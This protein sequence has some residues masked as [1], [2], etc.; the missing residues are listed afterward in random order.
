MLSQEHAINL[1]DTAQCDPRHTAD[2]LKFTN[3]CDTAGFETRR[4][5]DM[6]RSADPCD[7]AGYVHSTDSFGAVDGPGIRFLI[8]LQGCRMRCQYCH[9]PDTWRI[10]G[11]AKTYAD[12]DS[13]RMA[14][15]AESKR[16]SG[17]DDHSDDHAEKRFPRKKMTVSELLSKAERYRSYWKD[18]GGITVSGGEPLLQIDFLT[19]LFTEAHS[20]QINTALDTSAQPFMR[21]QP[22][23]GKFE[24]LMDST[25]LVLLDIKHID[26]EKHRQLTGHSNANILDCARYLS[27]IGKPV[28]IRHVLVPGINDSEEELLRTGEFIR[29]LRNV[30]RVEVLPY[31]T[32]GVYKWEELGYEYRLGDAEPPTEESV[33]R[34]REI[35][36]GRL[37]V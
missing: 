28:W 17:P 30:E 31:H 15:T 32:L 26:D 13:I 6:S 9:N 20:R 16:P 23:F 29:S 1:C 27:E 21:E 22:F 25:D 34:A 12:P 14:E 11:D 19:A 33:E 7:A 8:F 3:L 24:R 4:F 10:A 2:A 5:T 37:Q 35:L 18:T 36:T